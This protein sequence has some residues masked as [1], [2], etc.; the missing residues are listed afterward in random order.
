MSTLTWPT[1]TDGTALTEQE[2][3]DLTAYDTYLRGIL[4]ELARVAIKADPTMWN[5]FAVSRIDPLLAE[6]DAT[7]V[8]PNTTGLAQ[9][10]DMTQAQFLGLQALARGLV[11]TLDTNRDLIITA[12]GVNAPSEV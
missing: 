12:I 6:L 8:L 3:S 9:A 7:A 4:R 1:K 10:S 11:Q 5:A 2:K